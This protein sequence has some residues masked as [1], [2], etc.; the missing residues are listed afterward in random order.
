[1][2]LYSY[3]L[4]I[5]GNHYDLISVADSSSLQT[6]KPL[7]STEKK[8]GKG[9]MSVNIKG[10][11]NPTFYRTFITAL[12]GAQAS[13]T[14]GDCE[15]I[16]T[17]TTSNTVEFRGYLDNSEID[18]T[19]RLIPESLTLA[20][21]D[22]TSFLDRKIRLNKF[23]KNK[24]RNEI[25]SDLI[26]AM[27]ADGGMSISVLSTDLPNT[28]VVSHFSVSEDDDRTYRDVIDTILF[29]A[30]GYV[31]WYDP[32]FDGYRIK[33]IPTTV[34]EEETYRQVK[35]LVENKLQ[36]KSVIYDNDGVL[37]SY[38]TIVERGNTNLYFE[39]IQ[40]TEAE[41]GTIRGTIVPSGGYFPEDGDVK[42]IYQEYRIADRAYVSGE[43][44]LQ[45]EDLKLLYAKDVTYQLTSVPQMSLAP[46]LPN[47]HWDGQAEFYPKKARL[48]FYNNNS[49]DYIRSTDTKAIVSKKYYRKVGSTYT[50]IQNVSPS[51]NPKHEG[52]YEEKGSNVTLFSLTGTAVYVDYMNRLT[53][54]N[55]CTNPEEKEVQTIDN[56]TEAKA[57][58]E[59]YYNSR[60]Y[61]GTISQWC[62]PEGYSSLGEIV[63]VVHKESG[64]QM[65]H[66]IVQMNNNNAG[67][68]SG[69]IRRI[70]VTAVSLYGWSE[71][72][73]SVVKAN[74]K[75]SNNTQQDES[76]KWYS[77]TAV[78]GK[79]NARGWSGNV[80][81]YYLNTET[82][83]IY[84]CVTSGTGVTAMWQWVMNNKGE[85]ADVDSYTYV[86]E[87]GL[88]ESDQEFIFPDG[89]WGYADNANYGYD[90]DAE[91]GFKNIGGWSEDF[92]DWYKGLYVWQRIKT[93]D[94][95]GNVT[96]G[97]PV[98]A[99]DLTK[100]LVDSCSFLLQPVSSEFIKNLAAPNSVTDGY[101]LNLLFTGFSGA[102]SI[103]PL[104]SFS[105]VSNGTDISSIS[106]VVFSHNV[107]SFTLRRNTDAT[108][109]TINVVGIH[110]QSILS[111]PEAT[112][113]QKAKAIAG[114]NEQA[115]VIMTANDI[116]QFGVYGGV[117]ATDADAEE[118]FTEACGGVYQ[119]YSYIQCD[120]SN[121]NY[122]DIV[123]RYFGVDGNWNN[124]SI[125]NT[126][127]AGRILALAEK[128]FWS[129]YDNTS[130][131]N[132]E[133]LW[134]T[135]GYKK[136][137][138]AHAIA[139]SKIV[140]YDA[141]N[142]DS[143]VIASANIP[144]DVSQGLDADGKYLVNSG[145]RLEGKN[146]IIRATT[147]YFN[148]INIGAD[149]NFDGEI[150][151]DALETH[152]G[153]TDTDTYGGDNT[154]N[155]A[156]WSYSELE[157]LLP[158][159]SVVAS[160]TSGS[161]FNNHSVTRYCHMVDLTKIY[162]GDSKE[163]NTSVSS[164]TFINNDRTYTY[165][166]AGNTSGG[167][168]VNGAL[169]VFRSA[170]QQKYYVPRIEV[171]VN[172]VLN[173]YR[174]KRETSSYSTTM[175]NYYMSV[176][177]VNKG[178]IIKVIVKAI[179]TPST[180]TQSTSFSSDKIIFKVNPTV[181]YTDN[182]NQYGLW[183]YDS[184]DARW[185]LL[186]QTSYQS[187]PMS[188]TL[189]GTTVYNKYY[190]W[191]ND[192]KKSGLTVINGAIG[193]ITNVSLSINGSTVSGTFVSVV[194]NENGISFSNSQGNAQTI[195]RGTFYLSFSFSFEGL[196]S[197]S[198]VRVENLLP[199]RD[200]ITEIGDADHY[201]ANAHLLNLDINGKTMDRMVTEFSFDTSDP[202]DIWW[203]RKWNDGMIEQGGLVNGSITTG[204]D[205]SKSVST[206][207]FSHAFAT[208]VM[209]ILAKLAYPNFT[210]DFETNPPLG[211][212]N[213]VMPYN[214][215]TTSFN[216]ATMFDGGV[217]KQIDR[218]FY[219]YACGY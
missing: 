84:R 200:N 70:S 183:L 121:P 193:S 109:I 156:H 63:M 6:V 50:E 44:R 206:Y 67:G 49:L 139:T 145:F 81:D 129:L 113:A 203:Y 32:Q 100:A 111:D 162:A 114:C 187:S 124:L 106:D 35:Y 164:S 78:T 9:T 184:V 39:N 94:A 10:G 211:I 57:F 41:D 119:G 18:I 177:N 99:V 54:P 11:A 144:T 110:D 118:Y 194:W 103:N 20:A 98:Y 56:E 204:A 93:T 65:P 157:S 1:M 191:E 199:K 13:H 188:V 132:K 213:E 8:S 80:G 174:N 195:S 189:S 43:S 181:T 108:E 15:I 172:D 77:G 143:G 60:K 120:V 170:V 76:A 207:T 137:I 74:T 26:A 69:T 212:V 150:H 21:M 142:G 86:I 161:T 72:T 58:A 128:D 219:W 31:L 201:F 46:A 73:A 34:D 192:C 23:W 171:Y 47:V 169:P 55:V 182:I 198:Y 176:T 209:M 28:K 37:L 178:D 218:P 190:T 89:L 126:D 105:I 158:A 104:Y 155:T 125:S 66:V 19:S 25:V 22:K 79:P 140:L 151:S 42:E 147:G 136:E 215:T 87:Y 102:D 112:D 96:Y 59:W 36:T 130:D 3:D 82:G 122:A 210:G 85:D 138:I 148:N 68:Q 153:N 2:A 90:D 116:T 29:E 196:A 180:A 160:L 71:Y 16:V 52:W 51:D 75:S 92:S 159:T 97:E 202:D 17:E 4:T 175:G 133:Y 40:K 186:P 38:P 64:V 179:S 7:C 127:G 33:Q 163:Y 24:S 131:E 205:L 95:D 146:G 101:T 27:V 48:L 83:D 208:R 107:L 61:G 14:I 134:N 5:N 135:Y 152:N 154:G 167:V 91:Y 141:S 166:V 185:I 216:P 117:F 173:N 53:V 149:S 197:T 88:S 30:V 217:Y 115:T 45:N 62:E 12:L 214:V 165:T 123:I 168:Q